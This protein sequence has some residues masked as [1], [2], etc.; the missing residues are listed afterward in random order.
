[1]RRLIVDVAVDRGCESG[2]R[3]GT[4]CQAEG[5]VNG[6][7]PSKGLYPAATD[8]EIIVSKGRQRLGR[9]VEVHRAAV[10]RVGAEAGC[11]PVGDSNDA[12]RAED[13]GVGGTV[14]EVVI[15]EGNDCL[16]A[17]SVVIDGAPGDGVRVGAW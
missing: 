3:Q 4:R 5:T 16:A 17:G 12:V 8:G 10:D 11:E 13:A 6:D 1:M 15:I 9:A 7:V 14:G 2:V